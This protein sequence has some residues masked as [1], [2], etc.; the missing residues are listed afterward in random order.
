[1]QSRVSLGVCAFEEFA[2]AAVRH[3]AARTREV[4]REEAVVVDELRDFA[5]IF[6]APAR[7]VLR[8]LDR[9]A[10]RR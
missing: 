2:R 4:V 3:E 6:R 5:D 9:R 7:Q 1:M 8:A 10:P